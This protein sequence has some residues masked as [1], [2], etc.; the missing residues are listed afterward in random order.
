MGLPPKLKTAALLAQSL[1]FDNMV[2]TIEQILANDHDHG[3]RHLLKFVECILKQGPQEQ[4]NL[5][6]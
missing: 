3:R 4:E 2:S 6:K 1:P 5:Y